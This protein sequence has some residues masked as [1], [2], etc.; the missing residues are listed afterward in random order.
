MFYVSRLRF[1]HGEPTNR[2]YAFYTSMAHCVFLP[3]HW[4]N[5]PKYR[6]FSLFAGAWRRPGMI[7]FHTLMLYTLLHK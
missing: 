2:L 4:N 6:V 7:D 3:P 1:L 5:I